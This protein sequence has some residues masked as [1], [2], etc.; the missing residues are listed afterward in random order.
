MKTLC[1]PIT[2]NCICPGLVATPLANAVLLAAFPEELRTPASNIT[3]A[4]NMFLEDDSLSGQVVEC[5]GKEILF[6]DSMSY[7]NEAAKYLCEGK[8]M[9]G[10][11]FDAA[12]Q[13]IQD[14]AKQFDDK[15]NQVE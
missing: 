15:L 11:D 7:S 5:S 8:F 6:R 14:K 10:E 4:I 2:I 12:V 9:R 13:D 1:E 3:K